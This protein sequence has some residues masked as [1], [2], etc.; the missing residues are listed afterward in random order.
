MNRDDLSSKLI[1]LT[2]GT[3][4]DAAS[5]F[6]NILK[7]KKLLGGT[8]DIKGKYKCICFSE[9]PIAKLSFILADRSAFGFRYAPFGFMVDKKWL[10][11][12]GG[13][14]VIYQPDE[15]YE[16]L[17]AQHKFRHKEYNP[18]NGIDFTWEREWRIKTDELRL[19]YEHTTV[20][21]PNREWEE[22]I[23][24]DRDSRVQRRSFLGIGGIPISVIKN[25]WHIIV[26]EDLGVTIPPENKEFE[27]ERLKESADLYSEIYSEDKDLKELTETASTG[28]PE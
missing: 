15:E 18:S 20:V 6:I 28:W 7:E 26:L 23:L 8:G 4:N 10:F 2:R 12:K 27:L 13:R 22:K 11:E 25:D 1:H 17:D 5:V 9:A 14:P 16:I 21:V 24:K 3:W 19:D